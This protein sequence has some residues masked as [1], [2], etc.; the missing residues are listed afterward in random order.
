[1][2]TLLRF[3]LVVALA[4][5]LHAQNT[6][7]DSNASVSGAPSGNG[8][9]TTIPARPVYVS[10][11]VK[12]DDG[13][14]LAE[15]VNVESVCGQL[16]RVLGRTG[17]NGTFRFPWTVAGTAFSDASQPARST[18]GASVGVLNTSRTVARGL[19]PLANCELIAI[20]PGFYSSRVSLGTRVD[21]LSSDA[22]TIV[23]HRV[24]QSEGRTISLLALK[25]PKKAK[26]TLE[27]AERL[28]FSGKSTQAI[29]AFQKALAVYANYPE[30]WLGLGKAQWV[31]HDKANARV[32]F[33]KAMALDERLVGPWQQLGYLACDDSQWEEAARDLNRAVELGP[34]DSSV[35]WHYLAV[36]SYN[37]RRFDVAE[38][39][40]RTE[41]KLD[42][43]AKPEAQYLLALVLIARHDME[44]GEAALR[45][46][47]ASAPASTDT[48]LARRALSQLEKRSTH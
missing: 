43:H 3:G 46:Y 37:L 42:P 4:V 44:G 47:I 32:S 30:A 7:T 6:T 12:M 28:A 27:K 13:S 39:S 41:L 9:I 34:R 8:G 17:A 19:E 20:A 16:T 29:S 10:G 21:D 33:Q 22:G 48:D 45:L 18:P 23:L 14:P 11:L 24:A 1:M 31:N 36:A 15:A 40:V 5:G 2:W 26:A 25:A 38:R 35:A